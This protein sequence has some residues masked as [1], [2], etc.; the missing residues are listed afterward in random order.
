MFP[1]GADG[2]IR[3]ELDAARFRGGSETAI[4]L[5]L[6][7]PQQGLVES[8]DSAG[9]AHLEVE[10]ELSGADGEEIGRFGEDS[11]MPLT[12]ASPGEVPGLEPRQILTLRPQAPG[13]IGEVAVRL[14]DL[15][16]QKR[17]L[18]DRIK[19]S[20]PSGSARGRFAGDP[21][22][23]G[24]SDLV[25][26]W[27]LAP[28]RA[29]ADSPVRQRITPNPLR[30]VGLHRTMLLFFVEH[31]G[32]GTRL[33]Y[34]VT[35]LTD[36]STV[37]QGADS[38]E[39]DSGSMQPWIRA[40]DVSRLPAGAYRLA[41]WESAAES[42]RVEADFQV[43]WDVASW[44][45][46]QQ[47]LLEEAYVLLGPNEYEELQSMSRGEVESYMRDLWARHDPDPATGRN[48]LRD[49]YD[50]RV[51]HAD[52]F[53]GNTFRRGMLTDRGRVFVRYGAPDEI[54]KELNPQDRDL[55][56]QVLPRE[57]EDDRVDIIRKPRPLDS[58][59]DKAYEIWHYQVRGDPLFP[60]QMNPVQRTGLK[61]I[62]VDELGYGD[63][64]MV[65]TNLA[66]A[67]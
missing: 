22:A 9:F 12:G 25:F 42:C 45:Q 57:V 62:F 61:F 29:S 7:I 33:A 53:F 56:A 19:G 11:W 6:S 13:G 18:L 44:S 50:E 65:Y 20:K 35:R 38:L 54:D 26:A 32:Q 52:R 10:V 64:R 5:Y 16:G 2:D 59:D 43:L 46:D 4:E 37:D 39:A 3:F 31:Y 21:L 48:E 47:T 24:F 40:V 30:Y 63:M 67:F 1:V 51:G 23:C 49:V 17:G 14:T 55:L 41:V 28:H 60:E 34:A 66:G 58:R 27:D 15:N 8:P 36:R